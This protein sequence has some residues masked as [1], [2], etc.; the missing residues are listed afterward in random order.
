MNKQNGKYWVDLNEKQLKKV[1]HRL[2]YRWNKE[3]F[4]RAWVLISL[5]RVEKHGPRTLATVAHDMGISLRVLEKKLLL[6]YDKEFD[7]Y[8]NPDDNRI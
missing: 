6:F 8:I 3:S 1:I 2:T 7:D 5:N 4:L